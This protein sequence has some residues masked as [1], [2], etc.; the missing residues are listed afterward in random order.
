[1]ILG[2]SILLCQ[3]T[4]LADNHKELR[5][6]THADVWLMKR[7]GTPVPSPDGRWAVFTVTEP[8]YKKDETQSDLW[9]VA[10]DGKS[11]PRRLT[12][13]KSSESSTVW[14]PDGSRIAFTA[15]RGDKSN[16]AQIYVMNMTGP[17]EAV[18]ITDWPTGARNPKWSPDSTMIAFESSVYPGTVDKKEIAKEK[19]RRKALDYN[20]SSYEVFPIRQ[21][22][23]WRNDL[24]THLFIQKAEAGA[25]VK[26]LLGGTKLVSNPGFYGV[27]SRSGDSL[28]A[29]W[30]PDGQSLVISATTELHK[31]AY[32]KNYY[33]LYQVSVSGGEPKALTSGSDYSCHSAK[34]SPDNK[35]LICNYSPSTNYVYEQTELARLSW[36][37]VDSPKVLTDKFDR[38][39]SGYDFVSGGKSIAMSA[40]EHGRVRVFTM[41]SK[42]GKVTPVNSNS[43]G[44]YAGVRAAGKSLVARWESSA[45]PAEIVRI[46]P[47]NGK[48]KTLTSF[49]SER[50]AEL[51]RKAYLEFW[52]ESEKGRKVHSWLALPPAFDKTKKYPLVTMIHGGPHS[53][54]RDADHVRW[55]PHLLASAGYVVILTDY[56]GSVGYGE[57]FAQN[58]QGDP[59][60][61]PGD[62]I[63]QAIDEAIKRYEFIDETRLAAT[64]ASYGGHLINWF[65]SKS[66][67]FKT[68]VGHAGLVSLEGQWASSDVIY[69]RELNNGGPPWGE[70]AVWREQS[71]S[72]YAD[73]WSTPMMLTI[74]EKDFRVP[75]NQTIAAWSFLKRKQVPG[76]LLVFHD[77]NHWVM[78][79]SEA[80]HYWSEVHEWLGRYLGD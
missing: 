5:P 10:L 66:K 33:H 60:K 9:I 54:S 71:P 50:A 18:Q 56:T 15:K 76:K 16:P 31:T 78:K 58:I 64:G 67:R 74:G 22:D 77:A 36:P 43:R 19:K 46:N 59:L 38:S 1:M 55:S 37:K 73:Q 48:H 4:V 6:V 65:Q 20:V 30:A 28:R 14:S 79:G 44:V 3:S 68:L 45:T 41:S 51:D 2:C 42:G 80:K 21:W 26:N 32:S 12:S 69:H 39:V 75:V 40:N 13:T 34:F 49:N 72:T 52:F 11:K 23:R 25:E 57:K 29:A 70:S 24:Q 8:S 7:L 61:T 63:I 53:S 35:S 17:G 47:S 62:E 27:P